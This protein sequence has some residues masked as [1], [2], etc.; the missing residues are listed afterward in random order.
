MNSLE[1]GDIPSLQE[2]VSVVG[3][4]QGNSIINYY[5]SF[6]FISDPNSISVKRKHEVKFTQNHSCLS[7]VQFTSIHPLHYFYQVHELLVNATLCTCMKECY[8]TIWLSDG[9]MR[10]QSSDNVSSLFRSIMCDHVS[11]SIYV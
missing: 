4:P 5:H 9:F 7:Y 1:L 10:N 3:Y 11:S 8:S 2:A 6:Y